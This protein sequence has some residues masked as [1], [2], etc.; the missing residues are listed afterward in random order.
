MATVK[1]Q[2]GILPVGSDENEFHRER[3]WGIIERVAYPDALPDH[4]ESFTFPVSLQVAPDH[5][6][7]YDITSLGWRAPAMYERFLRGELREGQEV[8]INGYVREE[9]R[10]NPNKESGID[11]RIVFAARVLP[12]VKRSSEN[13]SSA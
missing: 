9:E 5:T 10:M 8:V 1:E 4:V 6:L 11:S 7:R 12:V 3:V 2:N 13:G